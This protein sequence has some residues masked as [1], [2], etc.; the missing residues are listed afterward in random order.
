MPFV[1]DRSEYSYRIL[2]KYDNSSLSS[3][4]IN[5]P[6][7]VKLTSQNF[8]FG[9]ARSDGNDLVFVDEDRETVLDFQKARY[10]LNEEIA[11][12]WVRLPSL[13][14]NIFFVYFGN[15]EQSED[16]S[17]KNVWNNGYNTVY[18]G[19]TESPTSF[20]D[21]TSTNIYLFN[22]FYEKMLT[23]DVNLSEGMKV[24]FLNNYIPDLEDSLFS[25]ISSYQIAPGKWYPENGFDLQNIQL[26][27]TDNILSWSADTTYLRF[28]DQQ[29]NCAV[30]YHGD[31]LLMLLLFECDGVNV[32][33]INFDESF[34]LEI[35]WK[36]EMYISEP[37]I[38]HVEILSPQEN[39][40]D[41]SFNNPIIG[42]EFI[43][44]KIIDNHIA[45]E[46]E[47]YKNNELIFTSEENP[48]NLLNIVPD[49]PNYPIGET[50]KV[51]A[52]Y[53]GETLGWGSWSKFVSYTYSNPVPNIVNI[54]YPEN[55]FETDFSKMIIKTSNFI[56][57]ID[58]E[59]HLQTELEVYKNGIL[60]DTYTNE[61][62]STTHIFGSLQENNEG[63][64]VRCR[65]KGSILGWSDWSSFISFSTVEFFSG[66]V[67][68]NRGSLI[69]LKKTNPMQIVKRYPQTLSRF[70]I[71]SNGYMYICDT[72]CIYKMDMVTKT[73]LNY[74]VIPDSEATSSSTS[75]IGVD[76]LEELPNGDI[77]V[78][79]SSFR[80]NC[81]IDEDTNVVHY[82]STSLSY[83]RFAIYYNDK[84]YVVD[85]S[86]VRKFDL[87][88]GV[89]VSPIIPDNYNIGSAIYDMKLYKGEI[90]IS[91]RNEGITRWNADTFELIET[92]PL[93][94]GTI[95][96]IYAICFD[97]YDHI[98]IYKHST[99]VLS[100]SIEKY[101]ISGNEWLFQTAT[102]TNVD[103]GDLYTTNMYWDDGHIYCRQRNSRV[104]K[105]DDNLSYLTLYRPFSVDGITLSAL[106]DMRH[107]YKDNNNEIYICGND[108]I[109]AIIKINK[110]TMTDDTLYVSNFDTIHLMAADDNYIYFTHEL[111]FNNLHKIVK[112]RKDDF[113][114]Q[115]GGYKDLGTLHTN[116]NI[117]TMIAD[118]GYLYVGKARAR[119]NKINT[120]TMDNE[121]LYTYGSTSSAHSFHALCI[122]GDKL[123][124]GGIISW[125][126][127]QFDILVLNKHTMTYT[128]EKFINIPA[129]IQDIHVD[130][131]YL[132]TCTNL[133][134]ILKIDKIT[135]QIIWT[136]IITSEV[137]YNIAI[138]NDF[139]YAGTSTGRLYKI[140]ITTGT[141]IKAVNATPHHVYRLIHRNGLLM[142]CTQQYYA[143]YS[144]DLF[145]LQDFEDIQET[146]WDFVLS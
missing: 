71:H 28:I 100:R 34:K 25:S 105:Y 104:T 98:Y 7:Y 132:Y 4:Q 53:K 129:T 44:K 81:I 76:C 92:A 87:E 122:E 123:Y 101:L 9:L 61:S 66:F 89:L 49:F 77:F 113:T 43:A 36:L 124:A 12:F 88:D 5:H 80:H 13:N 24:A 75:N 47:V 95:A 32:T 120:E 73:I 110:T 84:L 15:Q 52:R 136:F 121:I 133:G 41:V 40:I 14:K 17:T 83:G 42:S 56:S 85:G 58:I 86:I 27:I 38:Q 50:C 64:S 107:I 8:D 54:E 3:Q 10:D 96:W 1:F 145:L 45:S 67:G 126:A 57:S 103:S 130:D 144:N 22:Q 140:N 2:L 33:A 79:T 39:D 138:D 127:D 35:N 20:K 141:L 112:L 19:D 142:L 59:Q 82:F 74:T 139:V 90:Y 97:P 55:N 109:G 16:L 78:G 65:Y 48:S 118:E 125:G 108:K 72:L 62:S 116:A 18:H 69:E 135:K 134:H 46:W 60:V 106:H 29:V 31:L 99:S 128:D 63:Y 119:I 23:N 30:L 115:H 68:N 111:A 11:E 91:S 143:V 93:F 146:A 117:R 131:H 70:F 37:Y 51:R 6:L 21:V 26:E 94:F 102:N 137:I 114:L